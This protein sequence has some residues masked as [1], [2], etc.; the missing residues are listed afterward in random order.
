[1]LS[2]NTAIRTTREREAAVSNRRK[3]CELTKTRLLKNRDQLSPIHFI[4][5]PKRLDLSPKFQR[6]MLSS[7]YSPIF[8][9]K[10][11]TCE[12]T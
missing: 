5:G 9:V 7:S 4:F 10:P 12:V 6:K 3:G 2:G 11:F 8:K 1:M